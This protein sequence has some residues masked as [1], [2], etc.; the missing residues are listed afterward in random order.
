[1]QSRLI[2][3]AWRAA[4]F[5]I[6]ASLFWCAASCIF[7]ERQAVISHD[8]QQ[9]LSPTAEGWLLQPQSIA[10]WLQTRCWDK[11]RVFVHRF[12]PLLFLWQCCATTLLNALLSGFS[13]N[14]K[15]GRHSWW[16][17]QWPGQ[18]ERGNWQGRDQGRKV[19]QC[20]TCR[21][22]LLP[23][24]DIYPTIHLLLLTGAAG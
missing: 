2:N 20:F 16:Y 15:H 4:K 23:F 7:T 3:H 5:C 21:H 8:R 19:R 9:H 11:V 22:L 6:F 12:S 18:T 10:Y 24:C 1:M 13:R 14:T 17:W